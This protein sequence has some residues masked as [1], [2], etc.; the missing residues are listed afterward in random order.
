[1]T[2]IIEHRYLTTIKVPICFLFLLLKI[3]LVDCAAAYGN[4]VWGTYQTPA[5]SG[6]YKHNYKIYLPSGTNSLN[7]QLNLLYNSFLAG[8]NNNQA[9]AGWEIHSNNIQKNSNGSFLLTLNGAMHELI[10][11]GSGRYQTRINSFLKIEKKTCTTNHSGEFWEMTSKD[12]TKYYFGTTPDSDNLVYPGGPATSQGWRW[13]L[14][15]I[16]DTNGNAIYYTY[17]EYEGAVYL[18]NIDYNNDRQRSIAF[19]WEDRPDAFWTVDQGSQVH[20]AKRL[21]QINV[22]VIGITVKNINLSY[23][24]ITT[25]TPKSLLST[26]TKTDSDGTPLPSSTRFTYKPLVA[27][28]S[29]YS[30]WTP[31]SAP[32]FRQVTPAAVSDAYDMNGDGILDHLDSTT[33]PWQVSLNTGSGSMTPIEWQS[34]PAGGIV[35]ADAGGNITRDL[36]DMNGDG[37]PD[38]VI[39]KAD[40]TWD[41]HFNTGSGFTTAISWSVPGSDGYIRKVAGTVVT[42]D[43]LDEN[44][45]G[46]LD[47]VNKTGETWQVAANRSGQAWLL[48][49]ITNDLGGI[50]TIDYVS[51]ATCPN[52]QFPGNYWVVSSVAKDNGMAVG[53]PHRTSDRT[54][55]TYANG[56]YTSE[57][58]GFGQV[59]ETWAN[60][61]KIIRTFNQDDAL[62]GTEAQTLVTDAADNPYTG[63]VNT[64]SSTTAGGVTSVTLERVETSTY[65]VNPANPTQVVTDYQYDPY[66][67][68]IVESH[69]GDIAVPGDETFTKRDYV[70]NTDSWIMDRVKHT[71]VS[72]TSDGAKVRESWFAYDGTVNPDAPPTVGNLTREEHFLDTSENPVTTYC[73]DI[74]GNRIETTDSEGRVTKVDYDA[75]SRTFPV[76]VTNAKGQVSER[77]FNPANG[78]P[79]WEK[80]PNGTETSYVYDVF[81]RLVKVIR[82]G[83]SEDY[84]TT[85][86]SY[87]LDGIA[88]ESVTV[89]GREKAGTGATLDTIQSVDG[90]GR[91]IQSKS[92]YQDP[93][94]KVAVDTFYD[95]MGREARRTLPYLT[96]PAPDYSLPLLAP[97]AVTE[98]DAI[99]RPVKVTNPDKTFVLR[100]YNHWTVTE[101]DENGHEKQ[102]SFDSN[103]KLVQVAE[104]NDGK[105]YVTRYVYSPLGELLQTIDH[106]GNISIHSYD[107]LG[108]KVKIV[109]PDLGERTS[110][111]DKAGNVIAM[112]DARGI[113]TK[114]RYDALNRVTLVDYP[115]DQDIAYVYDEENIGTLSRVT[116]AVET[117]S[118]G[119]D[120]RLRKTNETRTMDGRNWTTG[121]AYDP[122]DRVVSQTYPDG[123]VTTFFYNDMGRLGG[124]SGI[125]SSVAYTP[126]GQE[127][128]LDYNNGLSTLF[129]YYPENQRLKQILTSGIQNFNYEYYPGGNL[130][131]IVNALQP[132]A[133]RTENFTYDPLDR[134]K[135]A[136][137][138]GTG[139][140]RK[141][142]EY[143]AIGNMLTETSFQNGATSVAQYTYGLGGAGPHAVTGKTDTKPILA[144]FSLN[145]GKPYVTNRLVKL[146]NVTIGNPTEF[147]ASESPEFAG[148]SWQ[149]YGTAISY[150]LIVDSGKK[151]VVY[152]KVRKNGIESA[153]KSAEIEYQSDDAD[154]DGI[155]DKYDNDGNNDGFA[156]AWAK[157]YSL[158]G[159]VDPLADLDGDGWNNLREYQQ[160]TDPTK[161]DNPY[162]D[163]VSESF[164]LK[165]ASLSQTGQALQ[166]DNFIIRDSLQQVG[167]NQGGHNRRENENFFL[168][169]ALGR[170][171]GYLGLVDTDGDGI[172]DIVDDDN[173]NDGM[174]NWWEIA[175]G[176][177]PLN[178]ADAQGDPDGDGLINLQEFLKGTNPHLADSDK[179]GMNDYKEVYVFHTVANGSDPARSADS[180]GDGLADAIDP[181][182]ANYNP[183]GSSENYTL[184][185]GNFSAGT[186]R[187]ESESFIANYRLGNGEA[188]G[189]LTINSGVYIAPARIDFGTYTGG[190]APVR[191]TVTNA[192][193]GIVTLGNLASTGANPYEFTV[194]ADG[195]SGTDLA[196]G[197]TCT[198]DLQFAP[199]YSGAKSS[200][201]E[202]PTSDTNTPLLTMSLAGIAVGMNDNQPPVGSIAINN[203]LSFTAS[204]VVTL[205]LNAQDASGMEQM[206]ISNDNVCP[207]WEPYI[208]SKTWTLPAGD[209]AKSVHAWYRDSLGNANF[210]SLTATITLDTESPTVTPSLRGGIYIT[211]RTVTLAAN[212]NAIINYTLNGMNPNSSSS[213]YS[214]PLV[215]SNNTVLK[216][217]ARDQAGNV[218]AVQT[219]QYVIDTTIPALT[220]TEPLTGLWTNVAN[221]TVKGKV[222]DGSHLKRFT[223]NGAD[224]P[225]HYDGVFTHSV[226]LSTGL[227]QINTLAVD[228]AGNQATDIRTV[229]L[230]QQAP[231]VSISSPAIS[232]KV[233]GASYIVKGS[234]TDGTGSG[235]QRVEVS[236]DGGQNWVVA[237]GTN[238]WSVAW[239]LPNPGSYS[240]KA[241][242]VDLAG[243]IGYVVDRSVT[244]SASYRLDVVINGT[245][246]GT[247]SSPAFGIACNSSC[248]GDYESGSAITIKA[249][250]DYSVFTGWSGACTGTGDCLFKLLANTSLTATFAKDQDRVARIYSQTPQYFPSLQA[251]YTAA[252]AGSTIQLWGIDL[253]ETCLFDLNVP[254]VLKGGYDDSYLNNNGQTA[255]HGNFTISKGSVVVDKLVIK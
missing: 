60:D 82:P 135:I 179:D 115:N 210:T 138:L 79:T 121:W 113:T 74:Y 158:V 66:G 117:V 112:T 73:Y 96:T 207:G 229:G 59:T 52:S 172:P 249:D 218:S 237:S 169:D 101:T 246:K 62:K 80:D 140:Y 51:S 248:W 182:P 226:P 170:Q 193:T 20:V 150:T 111:Y 48:E 130:K 108:R 209:G 118:Y 144:L 10:D 162:M 200:Q 161:A 240:I 175:H 75:L 120:A 55:F 15:R 104:F 187:R 167:F 168:N 39:A 119:Y 45:D 49:T 77:K 133:T 211:A 37:L 224:V 85:G 191:L 88:P 176:F 173:D 243:N 252:P 95:N 203:G 41:V 251:A 123:L 6:S 244:V 40:G 139:G 69:Y 47:L 97:T 225:L 42:R 174:P 254:V 102:K 136:E 116:D 239:Q 100:K 247:I 201:V 227:N 242:A 105:T 156:D 76:K 53:N 255:I 216:F 11:T 163:S 184:R 233:F 189:R 86:I 183:Y 91:V 61:S 89:K 25:L 110:N 141:D 4:E 19:T 114:Y 35:E 192:G 142:Y 29:N 14:D 177:N 68:I 250:P 5:Y 124:I 2:K 146:S 230:D 213:E 18:T 129:D 31:Q 38:V 196:A 43:L 228:E 71:S 27:G 22:K 235:I 56:L 93:A 181:D 194:A 238:S 81:Q 107:S 178:P 208:S 58:R 190:S 157:R 78:K 46:V 165:R 26:I 1:M 204:P 127:K 202:I 63:T 186:A 83:D 7:P 84:P 166:S 30:S 253:N 245:G 222:T 33:T 70:Y 131:K 13:S 212:E 206:C 134:L 231:L 199:S 57:F 132:A 152:F 180:D 64:W 171:S 23:S 122:L 221:M 137:D 195:C 197:G 234:A 188:G 241:R 28:F 145:D 185:H 148:A 90:F 109:D 198:V 223:I 99:G 34:A 151:A 154:S 153:F 17:Q 16:A 126:A 94:Y 103:D 106:P 21:S 147:M 125:L 3:C 98:F 219:E 8:N 36:I 50:T 9:G 217:I 164:V 236:T 149:P 215:M 54:T 24:P 160:G 214:V 128:Q 67:N 159:T 205:K 12:G 232:E 44:G 72:Y 32:V 65:D 92:E 87:N 143:N 155:P 220:V